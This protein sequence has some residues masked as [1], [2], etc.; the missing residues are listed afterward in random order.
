MS[1][2]QNSS[3]S[4]DRRVTVKPA[5]KAVERPMNMEDKMVLGMKCLGILGAAAVTNVI[6]KENGFDVAKAAKNCIKTVKKGK[7]EIQ[8]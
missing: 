2:I 4:F 3:T 5:E 8:G 6:L 7:T 1:S